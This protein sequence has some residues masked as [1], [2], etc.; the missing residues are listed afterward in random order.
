MN[1][2]QVKKAKKFTLKFTLISTFCGLSLFGALVL[3]LVTLFETN[4]FIR[5][6]LRLRIT[7]VISIMAYQIDGDLH[8]QI[9]TVAD[10]KTPEFI[11]IKHDLQIMR[12]LGTGITNAYTLRKLDNGDIILVVDGSK[13]TSNVTGDIYPAHAVTETLQNTFNA[14][15]NNEHGIIYT[16]PEIYENPQGVWLSAYAPIFTSAGKLDA[17]VAIDVSAENIKKHELVYIVEMVLVSLTVMLF[18][19]PLAFFIAS[20]I[21][22]PLAQLTVEMEKIGKFEL[23]SNVEIVSRISEI[24]SMEHQLEKMKKGLLS[25]KKYVPADLVR[26]LIELGDDAKLGGENKKLTILFSDIANFTAISDHLE[27][28]QLVSFLGEYLNAM[29][30]CLLENQ[31][32]VD[33]YIGDSV[34]A[35]WGAPRNVEQAEIKSCYAALE[36]QR[37][38]A[39]L[40]QKWQAQ[41]FN[42]EFYTR[43]GIHSGNV[44]VGN[45]GSDTR[46]SYTVIGDDV[47]LASRIESANKFY[48]TST[49]ISE[50]TQQAVQTE[51]VTRLIDY[52]V[53]MGKATP[54]RLYELV[55]KKGDVDDKKLNQIELY[56]KAFSYY[57]QRQFSQA[58]TLLEKLIKQSEQDYAAK[59][60][61]ER[62]QNYQNNPPAEN[63]QGEFIL[64]SK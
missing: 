51:F 30:L 14:T 40:G 35:F 24:L 49:L 60:L 12:H 27:P 29:N 39:F 17:V 38:I 50:S 23:D 55:G 37:Q 13:K 2:N 21:R 57:Q 42:F 25:F 22:R 59:C 32:T 46:M 16:E 56:E 47:N 41:G 44:I 53:L 11:K 3:T 31:A 54:I 5:E 62:C 19:I 43:I 63:W 34:M 45:I 18:I 4:S 1:S 64:P 28:E 48:G 10:E 61:L 6:Q 26:E 15:P 9:K 52:A 7:D 58:I 33:K 20:R 8:S 36:C